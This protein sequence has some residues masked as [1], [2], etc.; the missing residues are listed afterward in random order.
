LATL[1]KKS[2]TSEEEAVLANTLRIA[3]L[4]ADKKAADIKAYDVRGLTL[5]ADTFVICTAHSTPQIKAVF[6][7]VKD[8]MKEIGI[9][10][11]HSEGADGTFS[12]DWLLMD[13][14]AILVHVFRDKSREFYDLDGMWADAKE[15]PLGLED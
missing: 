6:N 7:G 15:I 3:T 1:T 13:Y 11:L 4:A 14:G 12:S 9:P 2:P 5:I 8:G 10:P